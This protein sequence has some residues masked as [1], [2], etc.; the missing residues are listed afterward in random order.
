MYGLILHL[1]HSFSYHR[2]I[3][4]STT[5]QQHSHSYQI[6]AF[7]FGFGSW[8]HFEDLQVHRIIYVSYRKA[9]RMIIRFLLIFQVTLKTNCIF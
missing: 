4:A 1:G 2:N 6:L 8:S 7:D 3:K 9:G 5:Q